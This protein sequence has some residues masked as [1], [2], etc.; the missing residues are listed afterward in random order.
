MDANV[1]QCF[2]N[3]M[4]GELSPTSGSSYD[5]IVMQW[6]AM[7]IYLGAYYKND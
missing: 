3:T 5:A 2:I 6:V 7:I 4:T 1:C